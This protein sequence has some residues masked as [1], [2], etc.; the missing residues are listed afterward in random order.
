MHY[1][2]KCR[3]IGQSG[4]SFEGKS[5][6]IMNNDGT[7][8]Y[9]YDKGVTKCSDGRLQEGSCINNLLNG[10]VNF[11]WENGNKE[12]SE[13]LNGERHGSIIVYDFDGKVKEKYYSNDEEIFLP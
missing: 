13:W 4:N 3:I 2:Y 5:G 11:K 12:I 7:E 6:E 10:K 9:N 1:L 8:S